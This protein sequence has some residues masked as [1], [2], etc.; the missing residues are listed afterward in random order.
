MPGEAARRDADDGELDGV[1]RQ[2]AADER[3]IEAG[4]A[5]SVVADDD[6]G[7]TGRRLLFLDREGA[8]G[9]QWHGE[10]VEVVARDD[11]DERAARGVAAGFADHRKHVRH[12]PVEQL[13]G[14]LTNVDVV[15][16]R[17]RAVLVRHGRA[18]G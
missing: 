15:G 7:H 3:R 6:D 13:A 17:E 11:R 12:E 2:A 16:I 18:R 5:P 9:R 8:A 1:D 14:L 4:V 10:R